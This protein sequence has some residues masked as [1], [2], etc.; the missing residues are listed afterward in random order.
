MRK[1]IVI[2]HLGYVLFLNGSFMLIS[3]LISLVNHE[4][5]MFPLL[6]SAVICGIFGAFPL[7]YVEK[8]QS[9]SFTEGLSIVVFGWLLTCIAGMLPY[10][11]WGGEFTLA[12][13]WFES[14]SGFTTTGSTI[15]NDVEALPLGLI[16]WRSATHWIGGIGIIIFVLLIF[17]KHLFVQLNDY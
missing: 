5:S 13:A 16:F 6:F 14:V 4:S 8:T 9:I 11:M 15:L 3:F 2:K 10:I 7:I 17:L 12:K 1:E